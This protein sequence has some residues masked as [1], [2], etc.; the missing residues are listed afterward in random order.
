MDNLFFF[1]L[2]KWKDFPNYVNELHAAGHK[3]VLIFDPAIQADY[4]VFKRALEQVTNNQKN[5]FN[6][7]CF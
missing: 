4:D 2:K 1:I 3:L 5:F 6:F 7:Y